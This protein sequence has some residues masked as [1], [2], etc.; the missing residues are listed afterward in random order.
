MTPLVTL[1][2]CSGSALFFMQKVQPEK[3]LPLN[4]WTSC[5]GECAGGEAGALS[6]A[7]PV[8]ARAT[9][10]QRRTT[11]DFMPE[12]LTAK[13]RLHN[14]FW[15]WTGFWP[16]MEHGLKNLQKETIC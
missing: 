12:I 4:S 8:F 3:S 16:R 13:A 10:R 7:M 1:Q 15:V 5:S 11:T 2:V 6:W 14:G 9:M